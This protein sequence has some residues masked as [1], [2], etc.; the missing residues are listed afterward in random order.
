MLESIEFDSN[1]YN[2]W[3]LNKKTFYLLL[4]IFIDPGSAARDHTPVFIKIKMIFG[5]GCSLVFTRRS[6]GAPPSL[7]RFFLDRLAFSK[8]EKA[9]NVTKAF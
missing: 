5:A 3:L 4:G 2:Y 9:S 1:V 7:S 6:G 8:Y